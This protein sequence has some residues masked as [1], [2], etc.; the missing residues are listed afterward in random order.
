MSFDPEEFVAKVVLGEIPSEA[1]PAVA[2]DA[3]EAGFDGPMMV[4][5]AI[6]ERPSGFEIDELLPRVLVELN[7]SRTTEE[8]AAV[9]LAKIRANRIR[10]SGE[11]PLCSI[12]YFYRLLCASGYAAELEELGW[13]DDDYF[14]SEDE[15][16]SAA[17]EAIENLFSP[18][19]KAEHMAARKVAWEKAMANTRKDWPY[20]FPSRG[21]WKV[22]RQR[23]KDEL[24]EKTLVL[25]ILFIACGILGWSLSS[26]RTPLFYL[27]AIIPIT[28][29]LTSIGIYRRMK[30]ECQSFRWRNRIDL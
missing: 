5:L 27:L 10:E 3:L 18:D 8:V 20:V 12:G 6:L 22:F 30:F 21:G 9:S 15:K 4:R 24:K 16:R 19:L 7:M 2:Q 28:L 29:I 23:W 1:M 14:S 11:D 26:W 13:L 17:F 25:P